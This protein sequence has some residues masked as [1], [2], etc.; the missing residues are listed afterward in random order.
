MIEETETRH[1]FRC[2]NMAVIDMGHLR[3]L[4][5]VMDRARFL[6]MKGKFENPEDT[7]DAWHTQ[8]SLA[9]YMSILESVSVE[10]TD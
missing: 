4:P 9:I 5:L 6:L 7:E 2:K 1:C 3:L 8:D 10:R